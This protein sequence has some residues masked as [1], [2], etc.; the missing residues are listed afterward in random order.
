V[1]LAENNPDLFGILL[2]HVYNL[3]VERGY[4]YLMVGL[5]VRDPL[6]AVARRYTHIPYYSRLYTVCW[7]GEEQFHQKLDRRVPYVEI[8]AL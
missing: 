3:A 2:Q 6:L 7:P 1:C 8:A 4:A 5:S